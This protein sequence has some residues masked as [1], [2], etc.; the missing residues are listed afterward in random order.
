[1]FGIDIFIGPQVVNLIS[2]WKADV[3]HTSA[4]RK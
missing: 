1:M 2:A 3:E 4:V